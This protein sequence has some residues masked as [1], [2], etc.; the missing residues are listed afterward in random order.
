[1]PKKNE[2]ELLNG[3]KIRL[4]HLQQSLTYA[5]WLEGLPTAE[6]NQRDLD[7]LVAEHRNKP[8]AGE[9]Y[10]IRPV[11]KREKNRDKSLLPSVTC[12]GRFESNPIDSTWYCSGLVIIWF[13]DEFAFPI[14][15]TALAQFRAIDWDAHAVDMDF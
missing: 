3:R 4:H 12:I 9:P 15:P 5:G 1:M 13:Q 2:I 7:R 6:S 14:D 10:L 8:Y 11:E